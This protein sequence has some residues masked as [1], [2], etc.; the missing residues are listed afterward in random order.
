M[1]KHADE[2]TNV[3]LNDEREQLRVEDPFHDTLVKL[4]ALNTRSFGEICDLIYL[5][6]TRIDIIEHKLKEEK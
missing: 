2:S 5:L 1:S 6:K 4:Y 3:D